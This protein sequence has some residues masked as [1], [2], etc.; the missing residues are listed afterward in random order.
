MGC[1]K[2]TSVCEIIKS[3]NKFDI[4]GILVDIH[5]QS[6]DLGK[7]CTWKFCSNA[8]YST[9]METAYWL[10]LHLLVCLSFLVGLSLALA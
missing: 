7:E 6:I 1:D 5:I 2:K 8:Q 9:S 4:Y 3:V 10:R